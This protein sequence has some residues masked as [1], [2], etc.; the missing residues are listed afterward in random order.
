MENHKAK[1]DKHGIPILDGTKPGMKYPKKKKRKPKKQPSK[2]QLILQK[3]E[4]RCYYCGTKLQNKHYGRKDYMTIDHCIPRSKGGSNDLFNLVPAC[5][6]CNREKGCK[7]PGQF[8][9]QGRCK[10]IRHANQT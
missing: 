5:K 10:I 4:G 8:R 1:L 2:R 7:Y 3:T 6:T 9:P